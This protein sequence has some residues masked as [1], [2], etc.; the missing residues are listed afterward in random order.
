[1]PP[2]EAHRPQY[3]VEVRSSCRPNSDN[4][5]MCSPPNRGLHFVRPRTV[6]E[7]QKRRCR[8]HWRRRSH[9]GRPGRPAIP[10]EIRKLIRRISRAEPNWGSPRIVGELGKLGSEEVITAPR[11]PWQNPYAERVIGTLRRKCLDNVVIL[12]EQH[13]RRTLQR[14]I[15]FYNRW[16][17]HRSLAMDAPDHRPVQLPERRRSWNSPMSAV[18]NDTTS[19]ARPDRV[20]GS[21]RP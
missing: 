21:A 3:G 17:V 2:R 6:L 14:Y 12:H 16:R 4:V 1:M 8:D 11:S 5:A 13:L 20:S 18:F 7:W 10:P 19:G 15:N 9:G